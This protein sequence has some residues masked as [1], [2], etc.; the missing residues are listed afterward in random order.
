MREMHPKLTL[1]SHLPNKSN[2]KNFKLYIFNLI[3]RYASL[4]LNV[5]RKRLLLE[6]SIKYTFFYIQDVVKV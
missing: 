6:V 4:T 2:Y 5:F 3:N 1:P